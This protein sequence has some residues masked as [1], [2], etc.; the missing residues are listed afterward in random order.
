MPSEG[1]ILGQS[2]ERPT[3]DSDDDDDG[4]GDEECRCGH[5]ACFHSFDSATIAATATATTAAAT[6]ASRYSLQI[7]DTE[8]SLRLDRSG[9][10]LAASAFSITSGT[11]TERGYSTTEP[12]PSVVA[13]RHLKGLPHHYHHHHALHALQSSC[14][15]SKSHSQATTGRGDRYGDVLAGV[16]SM[17]E[18]IGARLIDA[19]S[20][21]VGSSELAE[22]GVQMATMLEGVDELKR[23]SRLHHERLETVETFGSAI[24]E[25]RDKLELADD[26]ANE[27]EEKVCSFENRFDDRIAPLEAMLRT[28]GE[29]RRPREVDEDDSHPR[30]RRKCAEAVEEQTT[31]TTSFTTTTSMSTS[32]SD[33]RADDRTTS[34]LL[35]AIQAHEQRLATLEEQR[36]AGLETAAPS[37]S[38]PW[39]LEAVLLPPAP[40]R[41]IWTDPTTTTGGYESSNP[42]SVST[43]S[44]TQHRR[45]STTSASS[46]TSSSSSSSSPPQP[47]PRS[48][49]IDS[50]LYRRLHTRGFI[51]SLH[52]T[53]PSAHD[54]STAITTAFGPLLEWCHPA[55]ATDAP[56][57]QPLRKVHKQ[58]TLEFLKPGETAA[59]LW[60][61]EFLRSSCIMRGRRRVLYITPLLHTP[62]EGITWADVRALPAT[63][64]TADEADDCCWAWK[65]TLDEAAVEW[66]SF[67]PESPRKRRP[68]AGTRRP[69]TEGMTPALT[70]TTGSASYQLSSRAPSMR[71]VGRQGSGLSGLSVFAGLEESGEWELSPR[72]IEWFTEHPGMLEDD[73]EEEEEKGEAVKETPVIL[74]GDR[75]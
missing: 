50:R 28:S 20:G 36:I 39:V 23:S 31:M 68:E 64:P 11:T 22:I 26:R 38:A 15:V 47:Q 58:T 27:V 66:A 10:N 42:Q 51:K 5:H 67:G 74:I 8:T 69:G 54:V 44:D 72:T 14:S 56:S 9:A 41:G 48:F 21:G 46:P 32:F 53:G 7:S 52:V 57:W 60:N 6:A 30:K 63:T 3:P 55:N 16:Q 45:K 37:I 13:A 25:M 24:E 61:V 43:S 70:A 2:E 34:R 35:A 33:S 49:S 62:H 29:K 12:S 19:I 65:E 1:K 4:D 17:F 59:G 75:E 71:S 40:L 73:D 18:A